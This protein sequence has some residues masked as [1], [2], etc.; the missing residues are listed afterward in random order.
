[1]HILRSIVILFTFILYA[2][3][4]FAGDVRINK[5][6]YTGN[7]RINDDTIHAYLDLEKGEVASQAKLDL[8]VKALF[9]TGFFADVRIS[10]EGG[11]VIVTVVENPLINK[12]GFDGNKKIEDKDILQEVSLKP[13]TVFSPYKL[14]SD[15]N[16]MSTLY[17]RVGR[18]STKIE[19]KMIKLDQNRINLVYEIDEGDEAVIKQ[20]NFV[21]NNE[22][23]SRELSE[24][25]V[26]KEYRFYRFFSSAD[27][28]DPDKLEYDKE[29][30]RRFYQN[31]GFANSKVAASTAE[32]SPEK[33][34]FLV[35]FVIDEDKL[36]Y[37][38]DISF[39]IRIPSLTEDTLNAMLEITPGK[40]FNRELVDSTVDAFT[41]HLGNHGYPFVDIEPVVTT[42][43]ETS[44]ADVKFIIKESYRVYIN[45]INIKHNTRTLDKVIRREF[46]IA[47]GDPYN[48]SKIQRSKQ[49]IENLG[50]FSKVELKNKKTSEPD[51]IDLDVEV[52]ETS[53]GSVNFAAGYN[54]ATGILGQVTLTEENFL[55]KGQ[56]AQIGT[57]LAQRERNIDF[58]FTDPYFM[59][60]D[61]AA[62]FDI[63]S[64]K[65]DYENISSFKSQNVGFALRTGYEI[66]EHLTHGMRYSL[67]KEKVTDVSANASRHVRAQEG[68]H[69]VSLIG[70]TLAYDKLDN[71][72]APTDGYLLKLEQD[73]AGLGG[74]TKY[75]STRLTGAY[76]WPVYK[77]DVI[78]RLIGRA[79]HIN[80]YGGTRISINDSFYI[81]PDYI[82]GFDIAGIGP[83]DIATKDAL[84]GN[85]YYTGT[86]ELLFPIGLPNE[87]GLKA[88]VFHDFGSLFGID[89]KDRSNIYNSKKLRAS[90]GLSLI[91]KSP[92]GTVS[93]HYGIPYRKEAFDDV[94]K[95]Y[96]DFGTKF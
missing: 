14:H 57:T 32:L 25:I 30:L 87:V 84:G 83:R 33:D 90:A 59:D 54:T 39:D 56:Q 74:N 41:T 92:L 28:F 21:G 47:E 40:K 6:Q 91:W 42:N 27:I 62:G 53:T 52:E 88:G 34:A 75:F 71:K 50:F 36:Y 26:S 38:G 96:I 11:S 1:M 45:R 10:V 79:G 73:L 55:G 44:L 80:G 46:R 8:A 17:Q 94:K 93:L 3:H 64:T 24:A 81:G 16:R 72:Q 5:I 77:K 48:V 22:Y 78:L 4:A 29:L 49:R 70:H 86:T 82:R 69:I 76:F 61:I 20:I 35:T 2:S 63:F 13:N 51:K 65:R 7:S 89:A 67:K 19:P 58:S 37:F 18:Y 23:S 60:R 12:V 9:D 85:T 95:L 43:P 68:D 31:R 15:I 66:T